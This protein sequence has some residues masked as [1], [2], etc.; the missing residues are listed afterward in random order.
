MTNASGLEPVD[1]KVLVMPDPVEEKT[2]GGIILADT[3]KE[4]N[5]Y[6]AT[7]GTLIARGPNAFTEWGANAALTPGARVV[8][9]QYAGLRIKGDDGL[10]YLLMNDEDVV[11][12]V[13]P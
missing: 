9:A 3:T 5:K 8:H 11:G 7:R 10:D 12:T 2:A 4:K 6:A 13:A 1:V